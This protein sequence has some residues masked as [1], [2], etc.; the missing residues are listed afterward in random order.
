MRCLTRSLMLHAPHLCLTNVSS[1][2]NTS[3]VT[4]ATDCGCSRRFVSS[5]IDTVEGET[6]VRNS[7]MLF[8]YVAKRLLPSQLNKIVLGGP[9]APRTAQNGAKEGPLRPLSVCPCTLQSNNLIRPLLSVT[10]R[11]APRS[12]GQVR[13][14]SDTSRPAAI[15]PLRHSKPTGSL[16][17]ASRRHVQVFHLRYICGALT[18]FPV[19]ATNEK[20]VHNCVR[21]MV[22]V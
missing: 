7:K 11:I 9:E 2:C 19:I 18:C 12:G 14:Q 10:A 5:S 3:T 20:R 16:T 17:T 8:P 21:T 6:V 1:A 4:T 22:F 13:Q 15:A